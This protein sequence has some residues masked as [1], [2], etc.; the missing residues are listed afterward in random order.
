MDGVQNIM[1]MMRMEEKLT[2]IKINTWEFWAVSGCLDTRVGGKKVHLV[3]YTPIRDIV[4][5]QWNITAVH[6][7]VFP[8][9]LKCE[10]WAIALDVMSPSGYVRQNL[11]NKEIFH[12]W[13]L[14]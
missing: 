10:P 7:V 2:P 9:G 13:Y 12:L 3:T 4:C 14:L 5:W 11:L 6:W 8:V 1:F